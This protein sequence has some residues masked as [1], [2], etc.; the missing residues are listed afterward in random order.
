MNVSDYGYR[1]SYHSSFRNLNEYGGPDILSNYERCVR[2][3]QGNMRTL[4]MITKY[5]QCKF[6]N[7]RLL[8]ILRYLFGGCSS[9]RHKLGPRL[10]EFLYD[11]E[12]KQAIFLHDGA[13]FN[14]TKYVMGGV[15]IS[16]AVKNVQYDG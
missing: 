11:G 9:R 1:S 8:Y 15:S 7:K 14:T 3:N 12:F 2:R 4:R 10:I 16:L 5:K 13:L 6:E